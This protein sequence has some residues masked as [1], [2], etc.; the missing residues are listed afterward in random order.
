M[1]QTAR[2]TS[3]SPTPASLP[4]WQLLGGVR[5]EVP[6][7]VSLGIQPSAEATAEL[8]TAHAEQGYR[9]VKLKIKPGWDE[10]PVA[11]VRA[12][13]PEVQ[14]TVDANS[15]YTLADM[16]VL[17]ALASPGM[18]KAA[19]TTARRLRHAAIGANTSSHANSASPSSPGIRI[20]AAACRS[21]YGHGN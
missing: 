14:L 18:K 10:V 15:A 21:D 19:A 3:S 4:L 16:D 5:T 1:T 13:L 12:A 11:A 20:T 6:V 8:A 7:G 2:T 9:R 17:M